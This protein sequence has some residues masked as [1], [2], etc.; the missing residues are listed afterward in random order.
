MNAPTSFHPSDQTLS[1]YGLGKL[2]DSLADAVN[3]HLEGCA[4]CRKR[5]VAISSDS[6]LGRIREA[7]AAKSTFGKSQ[8]GGTRSDKRS[9]A[10]PPRDTMPPG[11]ADHPDYEI[12]RELGRGGMGVVYLAHNRLMGRDEVLKVMGR[13]I[14]E[15]PGVLDRFL[16]EIRAVAKLRHPNIV[17]AYHA[18]RLG[19]SIVF[20]MEYVEGLDLSK[21]IKAKGPLP[22]AHACNF[23]YQS[24]LGLQHAHEEGLVH[25]DIKPGNLMLSRSKDKATI[26]IL[27]C[28]LA[29]VTR[30][31]KVDLRLTSEG[32]ALGTPDYIAP[33]QIID[34]PSADIRADIYSLGGTL[35]HLLAGRPPF[36][37]NS[38]YDMFQA[39]ISRDADLL[40]LVRP[41]VSA[42]LASLV[43]KMMAKDPARRFQTPGDVAQALTPFFKKGNLAFNGPRTDVSRD[44]Q[45][46]AS[47][48][49]TGPVSISG[50]R[51]TDAERPVFR[52]K[53]STAM[54]SRRPEW[55]SLIALRESG[56]SAEDKPRVEPMRRPPWKKWPIATAGSLF[57]LIALG[58]LIITIRDRN[59]LESKNSAPDD[60]TSGVQTP[61]KKIGEIEPRRND[62]ERAG[63]T[64]GSPPVSR[65]DGRSP[66]NKPQG[67][68][69]AH[70]NA[71]EFEPLF[72][73]KDT[74]G[75]RL[76]GNPAHTWSVVQGVL[77]GSG[78]P[79]LSLLTTARTDY[80]NFHLRVETRMA[81]GPNSG[82]ALRMT[83]C[84]GDW[85]RYIAHI[86]GTGEGEN[87]AGS[88]D[89]IRNKA[90]R[91]F[92]SQFSGKNQG[93]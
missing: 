77:E 29:K 23:V 85:A 8:T 75:W 52:V 68:S 43:S 14:M 56:G 76:L 55:E 5:V 45:T 69:P 39:H 4:D 12:K 61:H 89:I 63:D 2:D 80:A 92:A 79:S 13:Q 33:E 71:S 17:T 47:R 41:E 64:S 36:Q 91:W 1:S 58:V 59:G 25:R 51:A 9:G 22:I 3:R 62:A 28:G 93:F 42:E 21:M 50:E 6:F 53:K 73:G 32:Q 86:P 34:A 37:A 16:R 30:E 26:K 90:F 81:E 11:L 57:G 83:E 24:A 87:G 65:G 19:E 7:Q 72:N 10:P 38:L 35:Y 88:L 31:E 15:R 66:V 70:V 48:T 84:N 40:N 78:P 74:S 49:E 67:P 27:D 44:G 60:F 54:A 20:A 46:A 18:T 82:I